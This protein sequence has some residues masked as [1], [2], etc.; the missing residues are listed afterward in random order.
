MGK[1]RKPIP[2]HVIDNKTA[3]RTQNDLE[4]RLENEPKGCSDELKPPKELSKEARKEWKRLVKLYRQLD[5]NILNDLDLGLLSAYCESR[6]VFI[7][8]QKQWQTGELYYTDKKGERREN[9]WIKI[10]DREG[11]NIAKYG[12]QLAL[13][14]VGRARMGTAAAKKEVEADP[15]SALLERGKFG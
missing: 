13:S 6:A 5:V 8:A 7:E 9:P 11:L 2:V 1:G 15:M 14:P 10:M 3:H 4:T 12:E